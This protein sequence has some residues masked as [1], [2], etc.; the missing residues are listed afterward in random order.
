M[1]TQQQK[2]KLKKY[3]VYMEPALWKL[4]RNLSLLKGCNSHPELGSSSEAVRKFTKTAVLK[5]E[6]HL[7]NIK[8][9]NWSELYT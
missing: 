9:I 2:I 3:Y 1:S 7:A 8:E 6:P 4:M 5:H